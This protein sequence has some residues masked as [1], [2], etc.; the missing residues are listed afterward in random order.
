MADENSVAV[1]KITYVLDGGECAG[2][3]VSYTA[4]DCPIILKDATHEKYRFEGWMEFEGWKPATGVPAGSTGDKEFHAV[5]SYSKE[6]NDKD[7]WRIMGQEKYLTGVKL[8]FKQYKKYSERWDHD[9][10]AFCFEKFYEQP[11]FLHQ[12]YCTENE[13][14]WI[15]E[16]CF[17]D[18]KDMFNWV[19]INE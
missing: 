3:P 12:G 9:H 5:W 8:W 4:E 16:N 17:N 6:T 7:D 18:F 15:C 13:Y 10:C 2:N 19:V 1:Y 11:G 14:H